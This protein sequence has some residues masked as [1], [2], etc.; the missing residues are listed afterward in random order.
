MKKLLSIFSAL[1]MATTI[2][3]Q[4]TLITDGNQGPMEK[5]GY[6]LISPQGKI[7]NDFKTISQMG[8]PSD[9]LIVAID[10]ATQKTG[11]VDAQTGAW[12][13]KPQF[14]TEFITAECS[15]S[16]GLAILER[17]VK[18]SDESEY[19][20]IDKTGNIVIPYSKGAISAFHEGLA[21]KKDPTKDNKYGFIDRTG[22]WAIP[23]QWESIHEE[24]HEGLCAVGKE[25]NDVTKLGFIDKTGKLIADYQWQHVYDFQ[26]G[27]AAVTVSE[28]DLNYGFIDKTGKLVLKYQFTSIGTSFENGLAIVWVSNGKKGDSARDYPNVIDKTGKLLTKNQY[29]SIYPFSEGLAGVIVVGANETITLGFIDKT[30][31]LVI[32]AKFNKADG[33]YVETLFKEGLCPT[34]QGYIDPKGNVVI[35]FPKRGALGNTKGFKNGIALLE[36]WG[37]DDN[38]PTFRYTAIDKTGKIL[39]ES[40]DNVY[41]CF[42]AGVYV[43]MANGSRQKIENIQAGDVIL[44][45]NNTPS[46]VKQLETHEGNFNVMAA[47]FSMPEGVD[48]VDISP[49]K[50]TVLLEATDNHPL[51]ILGKKTAFRDVKVGDSILQLIDNQIITTKIISIAKHHRSVSKVY[52]LKTTGKGYFVNGYGVFMK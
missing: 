10:K 46:V 23:A 12:V 6:V 44:D 28:K 45:L 31:K 7:I 41:T 20:V 36:I 4:N 39:Y 11:Y 3:A 22:K 8:K 27:M 29:E 51:S 15:F 37:K 50:N 9:G 19:C 48:F 47:A 42:P 35:S 26:D 49:L 34:Q 24:F 52:N 38:N 30:G 21:A 1:A 33:P 14:D 13:I 25:I 5:G 2:F 32:P 18:G 17:K 40:P 43:T 16:E